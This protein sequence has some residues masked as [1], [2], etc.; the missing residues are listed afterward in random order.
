MNAH[1]HTIV[2]I[3]LFTAVSAFFAY[4]ALLAIPLVAPSSSKEAITAIVENG[5]LTIISFFGVLGAVISYL[6]A[7]GVKTSDVKSEKAEHFDKYVPDENLNDYKSKLENV[8]DVARRLK[9][10]ARNNRHVAIDAMCYRVAMTG[11]ILFAICH[12]ATA[13]VQG[14]IHKNYP[15]GSLTGLWFFVVAFA[16]TEMLCFCA[17]LIPYG[18]HHRFLIDSRQSSRAKSWGTIF[19]IGGLGIFSS[20]VISIVTLS[21]E[22]ISTLLSNDSL[23][24]LPVIRLNYITYLTLTRLVVFPILG[25]LGSTLSVFLHSK[26]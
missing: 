4:L 25:I 11:G 1:T 15:P 3:I 7:V 5:R 13:G 18:L 19:R 2:K 16:Q 23:R 10:I 6:Q 20:G 22:Q 12:I 21:P 14:V 24:S 26:N 8:Y 9:D 17:F